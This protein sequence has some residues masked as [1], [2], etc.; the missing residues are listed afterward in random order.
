[1]CPG[2]HP[3]GLGDGDDVR[4]GRQ[5]LEDGQQAVVVQ[6]SLRRWQHKPKNKVN[7]Q[8]GEK[9]ASRPVPLAP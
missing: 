7:N 2:S 5:K 4:Q 1:M 6:V 8:A 9:A 3:A